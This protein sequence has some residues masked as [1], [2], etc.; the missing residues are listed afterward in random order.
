M[1]CCPRFQVKL[2]YRFPT[3]KCDAAVRNYW[4]KQEIRNS[5]LVTPQVRRCLVASSVANHRKKNNYFLSFPFLGGF[6]EMNLGIPRYR[7]TWCGLPKHARCRQTL[8]RTTLTWLFVTMLFYFSTRSWSNIIGI[9]IILP[10]RLFTG[11]WPPFSAEES[12]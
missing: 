10:H 5:Y 11:F 3:P 2:Y 4:K 6:W 9:I 1:I 7:M 8:S 12:H